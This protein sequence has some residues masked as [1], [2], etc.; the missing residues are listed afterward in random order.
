MQFKDF[1]N[2]YDAL[3]TLHTG[4][5]QSMNMS[6]YTEDITFLNDLTYSLMDAYLFNELSDS[7]VLKRWKHYLVFDKAENRFEI[8]TAFYIDFAQAIFG[9][10]AKKENW[11]KLSK[12]DF[13]SLSAT[14]IKTISHGAKEIDMDYGATEEVKQYGQQQRTDQHGAQSV[15]NQ[16]GQQQRTDQHGAQSVTNQY[17]QQQRTDQHGAQGV[18]RSY[19]K[20]V[21]TVEKENDTHTTGA[22]SGTS[23][24]TV[25]NK[26]YPLGANAYVDDTQTTSSGSTSA[27][28]YTDTDAWGDQKS[29]TGSREDGESR[30]SYT[31]T[32]TDA[33]HTDTAST[34]S[35]TDTSTDAQHTDTASTQGYTDTSTDAQ[36]TD[37]KSTTTH[38]DKQ[39]VKA[40][41]DEETH[42][43]HIIISP[44]KLFEIEKELIDVG[45]YDLM[46]E[47]VKETMILG[48]WEG[49][50]DCYIL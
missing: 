4:F 11:F 18:T 42:T 16:Y 37:S 15:T 32:S 27:A 7:L 14:D 24:E 33:Q 46:L 13:K 41:V 12:K 23:A 6:A 28:A 35:Y 29:T 5:L 49:G 22:K 10:L 31:D 40:Y 21:I 38:S 43:K 20:V 1:F 2:R 44:N 48:I 39:T 3:G 45:A 36:H 50:H 9:Y 8:K 30:E 19:D 34:Q 26:I 17:G 25:T 47:A